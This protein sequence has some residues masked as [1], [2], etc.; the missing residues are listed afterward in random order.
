MTEYKVGEQ[1]L[2][3]NGQSEEI[4]SN[5]AEEISSNPAEEISSNPTVESSAADAPEGDSNR[6]DIPV[7]EGAG[8]AGAESG[9]AVDTVEVERDGA[10]LKS[11]ESVEQAPMDQSEAK[12]AAEKNAESEGSLELEEPVK[13]RHPDLK[14][15]VVHAYSGFEI[16]AKKALEERIRLL[17]MEDFFGEV[18]VPQE[19]VVEL[20]RG[21]KKTSTR[22][23]FPGYLLVEM[24]LN[25]DTWHLVKETPKISGFVGDAREPSPIGE[26][27]V[28]R[29]LNQVKEG[30]ASPRA[31]MK[32]EQGEMVKVIDGPFTDFTGT[33]EE[34]KPEK[35]KIRVLI[36]IF[37][38]ATPV[39]LDFI[40]VEKC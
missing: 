16:K 2:P 5:P 11:P 21:Q 37:G 34:V 3:G 18:Q 12:E 14:W 33:V 38:R 28:A 23:Y 29:I 6:A 31:R 30:V 4:S 22:K 7:L 25:E 35:G 20:V 17:N 9:D 27:E 13:Q 40:Q 36:S 8:D 32:F 1:D 10:D 19:T 26:E 24:V 39:E 15:Y